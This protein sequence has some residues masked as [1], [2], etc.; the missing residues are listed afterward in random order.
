MH[1][2]KVNYGG[3]LNCYRLAND[4]VDLILTTDVGPRIIRFGF[5]EQA[6]EFK[7]IENEVGKLGGKEWLSYGGHRLWHAPEAI[8][9]SYAPDNSPLQASLLEQ[10]VHVIQ[11]VEAL[12]GIQKEME[13]YLEEHSTHVRVIHRLRN[14][15]LWGVEL[16]VWCLTMMET[17]GTA[18]IPLPPRGP[19]PEN[20]LPTS[21][22]A[23]WAYSDLSDPRLVLGGEYI[24]LRQDPDASTP[25]KIGASVPDGWV[26]YA[27]GGHLFVKKFQFEADAVYPDLGCCFESFTNHEFLELETLSPL[28]VLNPGEEIEHVEDWYLYENVP[29]PAETGD[30]VAFVLPL[31]RQAR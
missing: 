15:G 28:A 1:I 22:L 27:R 7:E 12:T 6:N 26:A 10:G 25:Q 3:W 13:V 19:H 5:L 14:A 29:I 20:L 11:P 9:R 8:P 21:S 23:L 31:V 18:I 16:A 17:G 30:M 2:E 24:F 4:Q